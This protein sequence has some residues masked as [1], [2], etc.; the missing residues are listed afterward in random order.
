MSMAI[1]L[2]EELLPWIEHPEI[3]K[4]RMAGRI[5][6]WEECV[7]L[8]PK[9]EFWE[10]TDRLFSMEKYTDVWERIHRIKGDLAHFGFEEPAGMAAELCSLL[11]E[12]VSEA[13]KIKEKYC[14]LRDRY[15]QILERIRVAQ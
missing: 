3:L 9:T 15:L 1:S 7:R 10:E 11:K 12:G 2:F 6:L 4:E 14:L 13:T 8:L 5:D